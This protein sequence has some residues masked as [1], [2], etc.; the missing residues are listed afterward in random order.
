MQVLSGQHARI[1]LACYP[2]IFGQVFN[3]L[4]V[5]YAYDEQRRAVA[6]IYEVRNTFGEN[7]TYVCKIEDGEMTPAGIRQTR[8]KNF[9]VSPFIESEMRTISA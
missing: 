1:E 8:S 2:R 6:L 3:P 9:Y 5:Y 7:H 4:S